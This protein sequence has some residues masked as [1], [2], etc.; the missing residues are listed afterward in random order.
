MDET[1]CNDNLRRRIVQ[2]DKDKAERL[3]TTIRGKFPSWDKNFH[4]EE[5]TYLGSLENGTEVA[6]LVTSW[7]ASTCRATTRLLLFKDGR[8][9]GCINEILAPMDRTLI[10]VSGNKIIFPDE[11]DGGG[12]IDLSN[13]I[14]PESSFMPTDQQ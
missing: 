12:A 14:P 8:Y 3:Y 10:K 9:F 13:G 6:F 2:G 11:G 1:N 5:F 4:E 7:G